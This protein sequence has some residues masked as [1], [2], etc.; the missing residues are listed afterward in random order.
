MERDLHRVLRVG[1]IED[2]DAALIPRLHHHVAAGDRDERAV[3]RDTVLQRRLRSGHLVVA[4]ESHLA[5][6]DREDRI[7]APLLRIGRAALRVVTTAP[8]VAEE[9]LGAVVVER[10]RVP[11]GEVGIGH[12]ADAARIHRVADVE[13]EAV[14]LAGTT[15]H[16][17]R[18]IHRD[19]VALGRTGSR[20]V[21]GRLGDA[22]PLHHDPRDG[23]TE[24]RAVSAGRRP[25]TLPCLHETVEERRGE[26]RRDDDRLTLNDNDERAGGARLV[27]LGLLG[28]RL[29]VGGRSDKVVEDPGRAHDRRP[30]RIPHRHLDH[31]DPEER[32]VGI[33]VGRRADA[34]RQF[35]GRADAGGSGDIDVD[36]L[37]VVRV[38]E[39]RMSVRATARLHV[40]DVAGVLDVA[41]V[42]DPHPAEA[43]GAHGVLH[44]LGAAVKA[45]AEPFSRDEEKVLVHR[46][47]ALRRRAEQRRLECGLRRVR[48][49]PHLI[50]VVAALDRIGA[51]EREVGVGRADELALWS[52]VRDEAHVP[53]CFLR[54]EHPRTQTDA[55]IGASRCTADPR[56][57]AASCGRGRGRRTGRDD[58]RDDERQRAGCVE[59]L[60]G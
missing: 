60:H 37:G 10:R 17:D 56:R 15:G 34:P 32:G 27:Q 38:L 14:T 58:Q 26:L 45:T 24:A 48:D 47:V 46:H 51:A 19:V 53:R 49:V 44:A 54:V 50:P 18:R 13:Q 6:L 4:L 28:R 7:G 1:P 20:A 3:V 39:H 59:A 55:R 30:F 43:V 16:S 11:V 21:A 12:G 33:L 36:V 41:D 25:S 2:R 40:P 23:V 22:E 9:H 42:E 8:L 57:N 35:A 31:L 29:T 52:R 5:A